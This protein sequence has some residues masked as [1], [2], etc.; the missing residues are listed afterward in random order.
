L[1]GYKEAAAAEED[2]AGRVREGGREVERER[3]RE[4]AGAAIDAK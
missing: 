3:E 4:R 1:K 2:A